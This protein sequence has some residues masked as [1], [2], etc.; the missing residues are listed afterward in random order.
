MRD[1]WQED[2]NAGPA[3]ADMD[4]YRQN[5]ALRKKR[6]KKFLD[7]PTT[8]FSLLFCLTLH[9]ILELPVKVCFR[10]Y[11]A[12]KEGMKIPTIPEKNKRHNLARRCRV[13]QSEVLDVPDLDCLSEERAYTIADLKRV[14][15]SVV[16]YMWDSLTRPLPMSRFNVAA[17]FWPEDQGRD[18]M[19]KCMTTDMLR[20]VAGIRWR[21]FDRYDS[22]PYVLL[23]M[24]PETCSWETRQ[25][26]TKKFCDMSA[27][28]LDSGWGRPVQKHILQVL[29]AEGEDAA[30]SRL[31]TLVSKFSQECRGVSLREE[32]LHA[33]QKRFAGGWRGK[34][35]PFAYQSA[36]TVLAISGRNFAARRLFSPLPSWK[37]T[38][39]L[40]R[41]G[42]IVHTRPKQYGSALFTFMAVKLQSGSRQTKHELRCAWKAMT[43]EEKHP[44][45]VRHKSQVARRRLQQRQVDTQQREREETAASEQRKG[46]S[47]S[48]HV[49]GMVLLIHLNSFQHAPDQKT[50]TRGQFVQRLGFIGRASGVTWQILNIMFASSLGKHS[51]CA[52]RCN[53]LATL[54]LH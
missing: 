19:F 2:D 1:F 20:S 44:W 26:L 41:K 40:F 13:K 28:C 53:L 34:A 10:L 29:D 43:V 38:K 36:Q 17:V 37:A 33:L 9:S 48:I 3:D 14:S 15:S 52:S 46:R 42:Q 31:L 47:R 12:D 21:I 25:V 54:T 8:T 50:I 45:V 5:M 27:C 22:I 11:N 23:Q 4:A 18:Q 7:E 49:Y 39:K 16:A 51:L 24:L 6:S 30:V 32:N 35:R